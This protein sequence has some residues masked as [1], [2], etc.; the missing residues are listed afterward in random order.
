[1]VHTQVN[2]SGTYLY[3]GIA[4]VNT[5]NV[6]IA[7]VSVSTYEKGCQQISGN[8]DIDPY[9]GVVTPLQSSLYS[10]KFLDF[11]T[12]EESGIY[13]I[14]VYNYAPSGYDSDIWLSEPILVYGT[15]AS[16]FPECVLIE[17]TN[18]TNRTSQSTIAS[19]WD[20]DY[21]PTFRH[22]VE[23][24]RRPYNPKGSYIGFIQQEYQAERLS[25]QNYRSFMLE[26]GGQSLGIPDYMYEKVSEACITDFWTIDGVAYQQDVTDSDAGI[27]QLWKGSQPQPSQLG[28]YTLAIRE[29][30][31]GQYVGRITKYN[32]PLR[33]FLWQSPWMGTGSFIAY[34]VPTFSIDTGTLP[35]GSVTA[36]LPTGVFYIHSDETTYLSYINSTLGLPGT[37]VQDAD[38]KVYYE[39]GPGE[40]AYIT[41]PVYVLRDYYTAV[42]D[43]TL[44]GQSRFRVSATT[45]VVQVIDWGDFGP[46]GVNIGIT[47]SAN[48]T[49][50]YAAQ[51]TPV[52]ANIFHNNNS[53]YID[54]NDSLITGTPCYTIAVD[55]QMPSNILGLNIN[56]CPRFG[57]DVSFSNV[58]LPISS[59]P[60]ISGIFCAGGNIQTFQ[61]GTF[62][63]NLHN[64]QVIN[65]AF[66][67]LTSAAVDRCINEY[68]INTPIIATPANL[69][70]NNQTPHAPPTVASAASRSIFIAAGG[71]LITD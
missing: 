9:T 3:P 36:G 12:P 2:T 39:N 28:W 44:S 8:N 33:L 18:Y 51:G 15:D 30:Y 60:N 64:C 40:D 61:T 52:G 26:L 19:G 43:A 48:F 24:H 17:A 65:L 14:R 70:L 58:T 10:F 22:R 50:N 1:M 38:G 55:G 57:S 4:I 34:A 7:V 20:G 23:G 31:N 59:V 46:Y 21:I 54:F 47:G 56:Q 69:I 68:V 42:F 37:F 25:A 49:H 11:I 5:D 35:I 27:K 53:N 6:E 71:T 67:K 41:S 29:R 45:L 63:Y 66:N 16:V 62:A 13:Y 32:P